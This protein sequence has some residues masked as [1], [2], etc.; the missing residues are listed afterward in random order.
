[1]TNLPVDTS[2]YT[3]NGDWTV[4]DALEVLWDAV[5]L[6]SINEDVTDNRA[7][8]QIVEDYIQSLEDVM[9][10]AERLKD[11]LAKPDKEEP[12]DLTK[13]WRDNYLIHE[14]NIHIEHAKS[15]HG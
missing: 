1:M 8:L 3:A 10:A 15:T 7:A 6:D 2:K 5:D 4:L 12:D 14:L 9:Q 11:E 13:G